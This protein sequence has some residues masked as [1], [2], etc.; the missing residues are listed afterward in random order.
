MYL[1]SDLPQANILIT[2]K[3]YPKPSGKYE[4]LVCT[5][6]L[7]NGEKWIRVYPVP[8]RFLTDNQM[9]PKYSWIEVDLIKNTSDFR[10]ESYRP[11]RG[12]DEVFTV[13]GNLGTKDAWA[14]RRSIVLNELFTS[15]ND[16]IEL[17]K[18]STKRSLATL[19]PTEIVGFK[20]EESDR[21]WKDKWKEQVLQSSF[22]ELDDEGMAEKRQLI[23]KVPFDYFYEF[24]SEGDSSTRKLKIED[25]E[26]GALYWN[27][28]RQ[29]GS[30]ES[31]AND[32]VKQKYFFEFRE[33]KDIYFFLGTTKQFHNIGSNPFMIIGVFYPPKTAQDLLF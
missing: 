13:K 17:A 22:Y 14:A 19:K 6:G 1:P 8:Y 32:L 9:Y 23:R 27:C 15:M 24:L 12:L 25:W 16:L 28:L 5:A 33:E 26:I 20:I 31:T 10:P 3:A 7:L 30:D 11:K 21:E 4:E 18:G 29:S 2:V